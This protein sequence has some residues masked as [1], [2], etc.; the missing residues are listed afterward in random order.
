V[1]RKITKAERER[2]DR[3]RCPIHGL[4]LEQIGGFYYRK[5]GSEATYQSSR[6]NYTLAGCPRRDCTFT[7]TM[8][9]WDAPPNPTHWPQQ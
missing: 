5:D 4:V 7:A 9:N 3:G 8:K 6:R 1:R 2:L